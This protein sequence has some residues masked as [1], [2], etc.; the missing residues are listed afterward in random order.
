MSWHEVVIADNGKLKCDCGEAFDDL[1]ALNEHNLV[2]YNK[3]QE[4]HIAARRASGY[5][6]GFLRVEQCAETTESVE[7]TRVACWNK[8]NGRDCFSVIGT[9]AGEPI[10][11]H[12]LR[13][14]EAML[15]RHHGGYVMQH[16]AFKLC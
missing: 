5:T 14:N 4:K 8:G 16:K 3:P 9:S 11:V 13:E 2:T 1:D 6:A 15:L 10:G 12:E 7:C